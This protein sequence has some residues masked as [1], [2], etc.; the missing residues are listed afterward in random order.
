MLC[1]TC[2]RVLGLLHILYYHCVRRRHHR[3]VPVLWVMSLMPLILPIPGI[4]VYCVLAQ[5]R[6]V[7]VIK[8]IDDEYVNGFCDDWNANCMRQGAQHSTHAHTGTH[9]SRTHTAT[10]HI[11]FPNYFAAG[12]YSVYGR[13]TNHIYAISLSAAPQISCTHFPMKCL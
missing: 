1:Y 3:H 13:H 7:D 5:C 6:T 9:A 10:R 11:L 2:E 12:M 4:Q 8:S